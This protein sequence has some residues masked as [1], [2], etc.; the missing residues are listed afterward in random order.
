MLCE[1]CHKREATCHSTLVL[2]GVTQATDLCR[3]CFEASGPPEAR[4]FHAVAMAAR[5]QYCGGQPDMGGTDDFVAMLAGEQQMSFKCM[6]CSE[7]LLRYIRQHKLER[8]PQGLSQEEQMAAHRTLWE[9]A[10]RHM[11]QWVSRR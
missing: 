6:P 11:K 1:R 9:E 5:C 7:E 8:V 10:Q 4:D 2:E 3:E